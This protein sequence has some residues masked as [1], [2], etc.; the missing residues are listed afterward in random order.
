MV[1]THGSVR[2][3]MGAALLEGLNDADTSFSLHLLPDAEGK[4][5]EAT[6]TSVREIFSLMEIQGNKVWICLSTGLNGMTT[7]YF[8]S[9]VQKILEH[10]EAIVACLGAQVYWWLCCRGCLTEDINR[11]IRHCFTL[12][13][14]Q[15]VTASKYLKDLGHAVV[16]RTDG[17]DIIQASS[18]EGVYDPTLGLSDKK[19]RLLVSCGHDAGAITFG[20]AKEGAIEAHSFPRPCT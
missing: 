6:T 18:S 9:V 20:E 17:D 1:Q 10:V 12:S 7:G 2:I 13:Q 16:E 8:L 11:L 19:R 5:R 14:Q 15:K 4:A 3:S